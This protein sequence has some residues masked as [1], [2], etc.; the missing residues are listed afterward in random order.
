M[1]AGARRANE[2]Q[3]AT[4]ATVTERLLISYIADANCN[5]HH[6]VTLHF[7]TVSYHLLQSS[8]HRAMRRRSVQGGTCNNRQFGFVCGRQSC[9][10]PRRGP[11][12]GLF[13][14]VLGG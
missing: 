6:D 11:R 13:K 10:H 7:S 3:L 1:W 8:H 9:Y 2:L 14:Q 12:V 5:L 4:V